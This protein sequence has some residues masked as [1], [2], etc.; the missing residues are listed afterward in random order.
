[1]AIPVTLTHH[2]SW[3]QHFQGTLTLGWFFGLVHISF[4]PFQSSGKKKPPS[5]QVQKIPEKKKQKPRNI[6][7]GFAAIRQKAFRQ[8]IIKLITDL[9]HAVQKENVTLRLCI[10]LGDPADTG[11]LWAIIGPM[12]G[13]LATSQ[14]ATIQI[15]PDFMDVTL[16]VDSSGTIRITPLRIIVLALGCLLSPP[17]FKA[18]KQ[19]RTA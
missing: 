7:N 3:Q 15:I 4:S 10:G 18:I 14:E 16:E 17:V 19:M 13:I 1:L 8:R 6:Q 2:I 11:Q 9:W 5:D 12:A